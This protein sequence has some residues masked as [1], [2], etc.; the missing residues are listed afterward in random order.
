MN[1][2][3]QRLLRTVAAEFGVPVTKVDLDTDLI[4][5]LG[6][7]DTTGGDLIA[8]LVEEFDFK[9]ADEKIEDFLTVQD[10]LDFLEEELKA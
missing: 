6:M 5:D 8:A 2:I 4:E 9:I 7:T 3:E 10:I 1:A